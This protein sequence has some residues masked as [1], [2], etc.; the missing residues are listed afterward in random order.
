MPTCGEFNF[1]TVKMYQQSLVFPNVFTLEE[2]A[3]Y[4]KLSNV[5]QLPPPD[6]MHLLRILVEELDTD[7]KSVSSVETDE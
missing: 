7:C 5:R 1:G 4:L 2:V 6:K 3:S